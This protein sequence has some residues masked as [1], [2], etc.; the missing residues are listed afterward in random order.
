M[1]ASLSPIPMY[2]EQSRRDL[3]EAA[4]WFIAAE[5]KVAKDLLQTAPL[6]HRVEFF[7]FVLLYQVRG[8][9]RKS[10]ETVDVPSPQSWDSED[11]FLSLGLSLEGIKFD[12]ATVATAARDLGMHGI[13]RMME[14]LHLEANF[15][16]RWP[17]FGKCA[18]AYHNA[19]EKD[20]DLE[21]L[22]CAKMIIADNV[23]TGPESHSFLLN[24]RTTPQDAEDALSVAE[25]TTSDPLISE[26]LA[27]QLSAAAP[28]REAL[29]GIFDVPFERKELLLGHSNNSDYLRARSRAAFEAYLD[30]EHLFSQAGSR[31]GCSAIAVRKMSLILRL[32]IQPDALWSGSSPYKASLERLR[33]A[34]RD[35]TALA[36]DFF[37][38]KFVLVLQSL[39]SPFRLDQKLEVLHGI[40][41][42]GWQWGLE[43]FCFD[44]TVALGHLAYHAGHWFRY[45]C[46][47][48]TRAWRAYELAQV[49]LS[50]KH[51]FAHHKFVISFSLFALY[52]SAG[53]RKDAGSELGELQRDLPSL[54][55]KEESRIQVPSVRI[56]IDSRDPICYSSRVLRMFM[57]LCSITGPTVEDC[58][59]MS[60]LVRG[61]EA[62][63]T[64]DSEREEMEWM[65]KEAELITVK[66]LWVE[67]FERG[68]ING[69]RSFARKYLIL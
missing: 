14:R 46:G 22:A 39:F 4:P 36:R 67:H 8:A 42:W 51:F 61:A 10:P 20:G 32:A 54:T 25:H 63:T 19:C 11:R 1:A 65:K 7:A 33:D 34:A 59:V 60:E 40:G 56:S 29:R 27:R 26:E 55:A 16:L 17:L 52:V 58:R 6:E 50:K 21:G 45:Q 35:A 64:S 41:T 47:I 3:K 28:D 53:L 9:L 68:D 37:Q 23:P 2:S 69:T 5:V 12:S 43:T 48:M 31:R 13:T 24:F 57:N 49:I 15:V 44:F 66:R 30:A 18:I 38:P 62:C